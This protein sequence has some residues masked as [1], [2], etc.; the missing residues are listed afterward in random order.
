VAKS[1]TNGA[2]PGSAVIFPEKY[3]VLKRAQGLNTYSAHPTT[4]AAA[5]VTCQ[6][7]RDPALPM[8]VAR[9][10]AAF[11]SVLTPFIGADRLIRDT[12]GEGLYLFLELDQ[13]PPFPDAPAIGHNQL[14]QAE[15]L[16]TQRTMTGTVSRHALR[17]HLPINAEEIVY[18]AVALAI[19]RVAERIE[20]GQ[21]DPVSEYV[22]R[23]GGPSGLAQR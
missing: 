8:M 17:V 1:L 4:L 22:L 7:M 5:Y 10:R 6:L 21:W 18:Q 15:L 11:N 20:R 3:A 12:R 14:M 19:G 9:N 13:R 23:E 2:V 16:G